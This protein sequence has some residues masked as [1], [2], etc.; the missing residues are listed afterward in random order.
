MKWGKI[1][2]AHMSPQSFPE[3]TTLH[4]G[5]GEKCTRVDVFIY[6]NFL[7][8]SGALPS[9]TL[10]ASIT[11]VGSVRHNVIKGR[12]SVSTLELSG[13]KFLLP[14][15]ERGILCELQIARI[16]SWLKAVYTRGRGSVRVRLL[17]TSQ[18]TST[19]QSWNCAH[20]ERRAPLHYSVV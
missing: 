15:G 1:A 8:H 16:V 12:F 18:V 3:A 5:G 13:T 20:T 10:S 7:R 6:R 14:G 17:E 9:W 4:S 19:L 2:L 11:V